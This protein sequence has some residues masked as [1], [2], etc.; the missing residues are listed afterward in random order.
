VV[1][2]CTARSIGHQNVR[3][4]VCVCV[5]SMEGASLWNRSTEG[6]GVYISMMGVEGTDN[7]TRGGGV[8]DGWVVRVGM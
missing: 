3:D 6:G 8:D 4:G 1:T 5:E 2:S 7:G